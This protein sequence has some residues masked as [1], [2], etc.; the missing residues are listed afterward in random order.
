M[1]LIKQEDN[2]MNNWIR[3]A[4]RLPDHDR[5]VLIVTRSKNG[6]RQID[7]GYCDGQRIV[8]RGTAQVT[9]WMEMPEL[10]EEG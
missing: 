9:H 2:N 5:D 7:K 1:E 4:E 3:T 6:H 10:P 8:H